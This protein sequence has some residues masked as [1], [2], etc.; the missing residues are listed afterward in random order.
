MRPREI[1][2]SIE[3]KPDNGSCESSW[4]RNFRLTRD[5]SSKGPF[6]GKKVRIGCKYILSYLMNQ[7]QH[8]ISHMNAKEYQRFPLQVC[9]QHSLHLNLQH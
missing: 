1:N 9:T 3:F 8:I 4:R 2:A 5:D 6:Q 7:N